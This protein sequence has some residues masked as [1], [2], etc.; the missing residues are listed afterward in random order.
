VVRY[1]RA[2]ARNEMLDGAMI[3]AVAARTGQSNQAV[4]KPN[5]VI[6][7]FTAQIG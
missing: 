1:A 4:G 3:T 7:Y 6:S 5:S 2:I